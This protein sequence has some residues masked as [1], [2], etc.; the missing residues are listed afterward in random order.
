[1][2]SF[3]GYP[4]VKWRIK[5]PLDSSPRNLWWR[6]ASTGLQTAIL[7][8]VPGSIWILRE[9]FEVPVNWTKVVALDA[10]QV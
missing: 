7:R 4:R 8:S 10:S 2:T 3:A 9:R 5:S 1:M 6:L